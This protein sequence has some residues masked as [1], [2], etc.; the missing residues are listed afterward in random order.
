MQHGP[1]M[2]VAATR[3]RPWSDLLFRGIHFMLCLPCH[4]DHLQGG[5]RRQNPGRWRQH[6]SLLRHRSLTGQG[7][8]YKT[9]LSSRGATCRMLRTIMQS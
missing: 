4:V 7:S 6:A 2:A 3:R 9:W 8:H 1:A 5:P